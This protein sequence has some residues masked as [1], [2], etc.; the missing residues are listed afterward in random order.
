MFNKISLNHFVSFQLQII[1]KRCDFN[2]TKCEN[3]DTILLPDVCKLFELKDKLWTDFMMHAHPKL[4]CPFNMKTIDITN[5]TVDLG[6]IAY[7]PLDGY[8]WTF[9]MRTFNPPA[10]GQKKKQ[11]LFCGMYEVIVTR[12]QHEKGNPN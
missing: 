1:V 5:A 8:D 7:L 9:L 4:K 6:Y 12:G 11:M 2:K 3:F 10:K